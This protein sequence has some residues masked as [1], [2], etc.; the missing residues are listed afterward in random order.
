MNEGIG[1]SGPGFG[2]YPYPA[3]GVAGSEYQVVY[4]AGSTDFPFSSAVPDVEAAAVLV[5]GP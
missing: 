1:G 4:S 2:W 3:S 5:P